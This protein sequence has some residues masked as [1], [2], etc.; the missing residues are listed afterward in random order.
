MAGQVRREVFERL[1]TLREQY[2]R[3]NQTDLVEAALAYYLDHAEMGLDAN[4]KPFAQSPPPSI[5][6]KK[7]VSKA[8]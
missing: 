7:R 5:P 4:L 3:L 1:E 6:Q 2:P 8:G